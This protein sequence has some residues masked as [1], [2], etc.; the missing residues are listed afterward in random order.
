MAAG[1]SH[2]A[3]QFVY[4]TY[5]SI[6]RFI[7]IIMFIIAIVINIIAIIS[8]GAIFIFIFKLH[9]YWSV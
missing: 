1:I 6:I 9:R 3:F 5:L 7:I 4:I 8:L 2:L